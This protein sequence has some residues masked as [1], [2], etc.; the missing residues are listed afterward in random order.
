VQT[1]QPCQNRPDDRGDDGCSRGPVWLW[2]TGRRPRESCRGVLDRT[3]IGGESQ[4]LTGTP[5][6]RAHLRWAKSGGRVHD[7][8]TQMIPSSSLLDDL[9][10]VRRVKAKPADAGRFASLDTAATAKGRQLRGGRGRSRARSGRNR[11][12][13]GKIVVQLACN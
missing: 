8:C 13:L 6:R 12:G 7:H 10:R 9:G 1:T 11:P 2:Q 4:S 3:V 5:H